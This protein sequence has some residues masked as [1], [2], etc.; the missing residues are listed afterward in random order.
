MKADGSPFVF[1][2]LPLQQ[3]LRRLALLRKAMQSVVFDPL[4]L[5][6]GLRLVSER[7]E[8]VRTGVFDPLPL[9]Q[10]LRHERRSH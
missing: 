10:G 9:Q 2:P 7:N 3:G 8:R 4:P 1:D 6:Q 5:Q